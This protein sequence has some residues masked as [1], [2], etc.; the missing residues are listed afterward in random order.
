MYFR[1]ENESGNVVY[2]DDGC[3]LEES[4]GMHKLC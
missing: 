1:Y 3:L 4:Y 2:E